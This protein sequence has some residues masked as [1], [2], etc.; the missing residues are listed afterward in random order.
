MNPP[1]AGLDRPFNLFT[2]SIE[3][4]DTDWFNRTMYQHWLNILMLCN[5]VIS[6][7]TL[8]N[9]FLTRMS[10]S[11]ITAL[12]RPNQDGPGCQLRNMGRCYLFSV[13]SS[14]R[15]LKKG[16]IK[17]AKAQESR[18]GLQQRIWSWMVGL[19]ESQSE[20]LSSRKLCLSYP[21]INPWRHLV[22]ES[23]SPARQTSYNISLKMVINQSV[24]SQ[25]NYPLIRTIWGVA[26]LEQLE[27]Q[28]KPLK[29]D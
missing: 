20:C 7:H 23:L 1:T 25:F 29:R 22:F 8:H 11:R 13:C 17:A 28:M 12:M 5:S 10:R 18:V 3:L 6:V 14:L 27:Q 26:L 16:P 4:K 2:G 15:R 9:I 19:N 24:T 21:C